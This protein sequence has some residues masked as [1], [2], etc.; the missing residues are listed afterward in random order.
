MSEN[1]FA[2]AARV[3]AAQLPA[4]SEA[5]AILEYLSGYAVG[6]RNAKP[7]SIMA[8]ALKALGFY[9]VS[10]SRFQQRLLKKSRSNSSNIFIGSTDADPAGFFLIQ[11]EDDVA[12]ALEFYDRRIEA[13][14]K[15]RSRL[16]ELSVLAFG[17]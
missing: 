11:N 6:W 10:K 12:V 1:T 5:R 3:T 15:N 7:W 4:D 17:K 8:E 9:H 16:A 13:T 14:Q 2:E